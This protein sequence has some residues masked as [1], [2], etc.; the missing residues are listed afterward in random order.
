MAD[1]SK[2]P[3]GSPIPGAW[4]QQQK[5][6]MENQKEGQ[7][8]PEGQSADGDER[9]PDQPIGEVAYANR[10]PAKKKTGEF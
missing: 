5:K 1:T 6:G 7:F 9:T 4:A 10:D 2:T 8:A 3:S